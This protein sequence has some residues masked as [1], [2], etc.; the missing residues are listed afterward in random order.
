MKRYLFV[1]FGEN[2][3]NIIRDIKRIYSHFPSKINNITEIVPPMTA[4]YN[5]CNSIPSSRILLLKDVYIPNGNYTPIYLNSS[6]YSSEASDCVL[7]IILKNDEMLKHYYQYH[8]RPMVLKH[9]A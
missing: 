5:S 1:I 8:D 9:K 6:N 4:K 7:D 2:K 3:S